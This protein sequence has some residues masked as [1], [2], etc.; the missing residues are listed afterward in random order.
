MSQE[1]LRILLV[2][3]NPGDARLLHEAVASAGKPSFA[4][5]HVSRLGEA[6]ALLGSESFDAVLLDLSLPDSHGIET[7]QRL[8]DAAP[9]VP[10]IV[11]TGLNDET[12]GLE[13]VRRGAQD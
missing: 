10:A 3:D 4:M 13:A 2:E 5:T 6:L 1:R 8:H 12:M 11:L 9:D 7:F